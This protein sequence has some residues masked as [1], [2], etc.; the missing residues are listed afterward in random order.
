MGNLML[1]AHVWYRTGL[2]GQYD[3]WLLFCKFVVRIPCQRSTAFVFSR[4]DEAS[5]GLAPKNKP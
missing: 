1:Y 2:T 4:R 3:V 5:P